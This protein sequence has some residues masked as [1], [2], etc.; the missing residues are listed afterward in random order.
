LLI[1]PYTVFNE[2]NVNLFSYFFKAQ[3]ITMTNIYNENFICAINDL[4]YLINKDYSRRVVLKLVSDRY[5]LNHDQR[6]IIYRGI[7]NKNIVKNVKLKLTSRIDVDKIFW[8]DGFN[9][10]FKI[11]HYLLG[12][13]LFIS[14]DGLLRDAGKWNDKFSIN[15]V[16]NN[17][18]KLFLKYL[19][20]IGSNK[21]IVYFDNKVILRNLFFLFDDFKNDKIDIIW[22]DNVDKELKNKNEGIIATTDSQIITLAN[23]EIFDFARMILE[24]EY[25]SK[26]ININSFLK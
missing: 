24:N 1:F 16:V 21:I 13:P 9:V 8:I 10:I 5:K 3:F 12:R 15:A 2:L 17:S 6:T 7:Y 26:F 25:N 23:T 14:N 20:L 11:I 22:S 4:Y 19:N 18:I